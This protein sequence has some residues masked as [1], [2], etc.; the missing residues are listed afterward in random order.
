MALCSASRSPL[1]LFKDRNQDDRSLHRDRLVSRP[2]NA[3]TSFRTSDNSSSSRLENQFTDFL[4]LQPPS[5]IPDPHELA[6]EPNTYRVQRMGLNVRAPR[7][8]DWASEYSGSASSLRG[9]NAPRTEAQLKTKSQTAHAHAHLSSDG[10]NHGRQHSIAQLSVSTSLRP[11]MGYHNGEHG[12]YTGSPLNGYMAMNEPTM[13]L[14]VSDTDWEAV[15]AQ[16]DIPRAEPTREIPVPEEVID[17]AQNAK[18]Q[19]NLGSKASTT[20]PRLDTGVE[21]MQARYDF[22]INNPFI[23]SENP[24]QEGVRIVQR[25]GNLSLAALAFEAACKQMPSPWTWRMLGTVLADNE[26]ESRAVSALEE[27]LRQSQKDSNNID[28]WIRLAVCY[29]NEGETQKSCDALQEWLTTKYPDIS[30]R[31]HASSP[32]SNTVSARYAH[33]KN[34]YIEA[35]QLIPSGP[36]MDANVQVALGILFFST[37]DYQEAADCF[38]AAIDCRT[39]LS[40]H[41]SDLHLL[42]NHYG[43]CLGNL[44]QHDEAI[45]AYNTALDL[46]PNYTRAR[47]NLGIAH[48]TEGNPTE[49]ARQLLQRLS[50]GLMQIVRV[51]TSH[52]MLEEMGRT[53]AEV[54]SLDDVYEGLRRCCTSMC[55]WDL[56]EQVGPD[57]D[58]GVFRRALEH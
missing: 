6:V 57:M 54:E 5:A 58:L 28:A 2:G 9:R 19:S 18:I 39:S 29:T 37:R 33:L 24:Y 30:S 31:H 52:G 13:D 41:S 17:M 56:A 44:S 7:P 23:G 22:Q 32:Q 16:L 11:F 35:A 51:G 46:K 4:A 8:N 3:Y 47:Y 55:R 38:A 14:Q 43:A 26:Q 42:Y 50:T 53:E 20:S 45:H 15:F 27:S 1:R 21:H 34:M 40:S 10:T 25:N 48:Y 49:G 12:R 36:R